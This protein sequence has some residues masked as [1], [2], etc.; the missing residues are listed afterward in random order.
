LLLGRLPN[1][2]VLRLAPAFGPWDYKCREQFYLRRIQAAGRIDLPDGGG[3]LVHLLAGPDFGQRVAALLGDCRAYGG[4]LHVATGPPVTLREYVR[5]L[6]RAAGREVRIGS[7]AGATYDDFPYAKPRDQ[8]YRTRRLD[9][10]VPHRYEFADAVRETVRWYATVGA[11]A[12]ER[13]RRLEAVYPASV[14]LYHPHLEGAG[15]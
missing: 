13:V 6:G 10:I 9:A 11:Q 14:G 4:I 1:A 8:V 15:G 12:M 5:A 7:T 2:T 3:R